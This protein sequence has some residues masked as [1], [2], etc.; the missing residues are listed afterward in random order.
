[1]KKLK[2]ILILFTGLLVG[3]CSDF[4]EVSP[5]GAVSDEDL[6]NADGAE[7]LA[8][9]AYASLGN[10]HWLEPY[11]SMWPYGNVRADDAYKGGL[12][13]A[14]QG[15][16]HQYEIF[17]SIRTDQDKANRMWER[18]YIGVQ[19]A[20]GALQQINKL[21]ADEYPLKAQRQAEMRFIRGHFHFLLK[22][23]FKQIPYIDETIPSDSLKT[24]SNVK[25]SNDELWN[26]IAE[27]FQFAVDNLPPQQEDVG[28]PNE[29][30]A[31]AYLAKVRLYQAYEQDEQNNVVNINQNRLQE[32]VDLTNDVISAPQYDLH[33]DYAKNFLW[34]FENGVES[35]FAIQRSMEDGTPVGR[36]DM[37]NALNF[38]MYDEYGCCS[39]HRPSQNLVNAFQTG[40]DGLPEYDTFNQG[41][42][43][44]PED[45]QNNSFDPR[46][47]H[48]VGVPSHPY[49]YQTD[50]I[51]DYVEFTRGP[52]TYG[53]FSTMKEVQQVGCPCLT[54]AQ[55]FAYPATSK[56]NDVIRY[57]DVLLWKAE[58]LIEL[59]REDE[60]LPIINQVRERAQNS[61]DRLVFENGDPMSNYN[62]ALYQPGVNIN[63]TQENARRA[64]RWERRM[65]FA[66][67]GIRFFDL[68]R[69]G[70]A[71]ET[72]NEYFKVEK[73]RYPYF[74]TAHFT[75]NRDEYLPIPLQQIDFS[76]GTYEQNYG[77]N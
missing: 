53:P 59:G 30:V 74:D 18:I 15:G 73:T 57:A 38:P 24:V 28:R 77:W 25:Y 12:G 54:S 2:I 66:M 65:E 16:Y 29:I 20:N 9:A 5:K 34:E 31:K 23:L 62:I 13:T 72:L 75:K 44:E 56:N 47:D 49:K 46:L 8:N 69:W 32:V 41:E 43:R 21:S 1:M 50:V 22:I 14:D 76:E 37:S 52:Q 63:W 33:D 11:T 36:I 70:I 58:A 48:T 19:R 40:P 61:T 67:E 4:L 17:S 6:N 64:L 71:A 26:K 7:K 60:A 42:M 35:V 51:Y 45:F 10:D 55:T 68:V 27:D 39:F 3:S